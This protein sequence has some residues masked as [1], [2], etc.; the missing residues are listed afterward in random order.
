MSPNLAT[1][2]YLVY[3][4]T[5]SGQSPASGVIVLRLL[6]HAFFKKPD[7]PLKSGDVF[8][9]VAYSTHNGELIA[10]GRDAHEPDPLTQREEATIGT[11]T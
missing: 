4:T 6:L 1:F 5:G 2:A 8:A 3:L 10:R 7:D 9:F 11:H